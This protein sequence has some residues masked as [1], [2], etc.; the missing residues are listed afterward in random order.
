MS[1][2][3]EVAESYSKLS[4]MVQGKSFEILL[5]KVTMRM[6]TKLSFHDMRME[7]Y[8]KNYFFY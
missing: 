7:L 2:D 6:K 8:V 5:S 3:N 1:S 4:S